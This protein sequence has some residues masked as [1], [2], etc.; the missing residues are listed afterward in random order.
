MH[1]T[2][3][4]L[5]L[6]LVGCGRETLHVEN[7]T[8]SYLTRFSQDTGVSTDGIEVV[9]ANLDGKTV[10]LCEL[11]SDGKRTIRIDKTYWSTAS[12][13]EKEQTVFHELGHCALYLKHINDLNEYNCPV[14]IMYPYAF[15]QSSCY[16]YNKPYYFWELRSHK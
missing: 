5:A 12:D 9:F 4:V 3:F 6:M 8:V 15:G 7:D 13:D 2:L 14:S 16:A 1:Y 10:G 11:W